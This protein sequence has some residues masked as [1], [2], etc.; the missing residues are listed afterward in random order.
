MARSD[1][2]WFK[3]I[4]WKEAEALLGH[5]V[6]RRL[7]YFTQSDEGKKEDNPYCFHGHDVFTYSEWIESCSGCSESIDGH[8]IYERCGCHECGYKG[9]RRHGMHTP[10]IIKHEIE[11][12]GLAA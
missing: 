6:N 5:K 8:V 3:V 9:V 10:Y 11:F 7:K 1:H 4:T 12:G 2:P